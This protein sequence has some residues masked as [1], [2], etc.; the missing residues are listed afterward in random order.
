MKS[1]RGKKFKWN[2]NDKRKNVR[3]WNNNN[4]KKVIKN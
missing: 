3:V 4:K 2:K 1:L